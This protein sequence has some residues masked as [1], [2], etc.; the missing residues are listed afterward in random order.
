MI[1]I[2]LT[3]ALLLIVVYS[4][5]RIISYKKILANTKYKNSILIHDLKG[6]LVTYSLIV[7]E[8][9]EQMTL[10]Q[11]CDENFINTIPS[12]VGVLIEIK[13]DITS[14]INKWVTD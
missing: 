14:S 2:L 5:F 6:A 1:N 9:N 11:K 7:D 10:S 12:L 8:L 3:T 4:V 13:K